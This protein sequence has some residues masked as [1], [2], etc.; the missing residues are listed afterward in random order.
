MGPGAH[1]RARAQKDALKTVRN[2]YTQTQH[3]VETLVRHVERLE[4]AR[5]EHAQA[6][7]DADAL[8]Q[9]YAREK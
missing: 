9:R 2:A 8:S 3:K 5:T 1:K 4:R 6:L 7:T